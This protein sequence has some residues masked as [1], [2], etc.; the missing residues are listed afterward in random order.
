M[1]EVKK[2][3]FVIPVY[4]EERTLEQL[5][6]KLEQLNIEIEKEIVLVDD[7]STDTTPQIL[8][9]YKKRAGFVVL[10]NPK[11]MGKSQTVR[12]GILATT[13]DIVVIQD[14]DLEYNP[15]N[16]VS[17]V[18]LFLQDKVD[19]VYGN[20]FGKSNKV[21]YWQNWIGNRFLS[22][23]SSVFTGLRS[24]MWTKDM[25]VCYK[26]ARGDI[27]REIGETVVSKSTFGLEPELTAK[28]SKYRLNGK[29]LRFEQ[30][31]IDYYPRTL[32]EG[33]KMHAV[34]DGL[35]AIVEIFKF[36]LQ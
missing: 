30:I 23:L 12:N 20:R 6:T 14:A 31:S 28:F 26:M 25:E 3:S 7:G 27:F 36:N 8:A 5:V 34:K 2:I 15:E 21:I 11:N 13:G 9:N 19:L 18:N 1:S 4:N 32:A 22:L 33:K 10:K 35:K 17:F 24:G 29:P 16:L